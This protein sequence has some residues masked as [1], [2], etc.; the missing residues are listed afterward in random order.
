MRIARWVTKR[1]SSLLGRS[2]ES[3][4][5]PFGFNFTQFGHDFTEKDHIKRIDLGGGRVGFAY[6]GPGPD[7]KK[8]YFQIG[9]ELVRKYASIIKSGSFP[10]EARYSANILIRLRL[11][12]TNPDVYKKP[13]RIR[14]SLEPKIRVRGAWI[15][16][17]PPLPQHLVKGAEARTRGGMKIVP[18]PVHEYNA[19]DHESSPEI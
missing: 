12:P 3:E 16:Y 15:N 4:G 7:G 8:S 11:P 10:Q 14:G 2:E 13:V 5:V 9:P 17:R 6:H 1:I 19:V 18:P